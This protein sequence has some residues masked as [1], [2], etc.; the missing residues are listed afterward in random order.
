[1]LPDQ[2]TPASFAAYPPQARELAIRHIAILRRLP[3]AFLPLLL[4]E[5]IVYDWKFPAERVDLDRQFAYLG[6][7]GSRCAFQTAVAPF[8]QL[9]LTRELE[10]ADW[11]NSPA[12][13]SEQFS[14]HL[15]ATHQI[16]AFRAAAVD[17]VREVHAACPRSAA[18]DAPVR[19]R[20]NRA[21]RTQER[22]PPVP[23]ASA[24]GRLLY[25][26]QT[27][28]RHAGAGSMRCEVA[29]KRTRRPTDIGISTEA[30]RS[31]LQVALRGSPTTVSPRRARR[32]RA[33]CRKH[34]RPPFSIPKRFEPCWRR[35][36]PKRPA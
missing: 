9:R 15:W 10:N 2:L 29:P 20:G 31:A 19:H 25:A 36:S 27:R 1:M 23:Q 11:V 22:L 28:G 3:L 30:R 7:L 4:R 8:A 17:Y 16:D 21:G 24:Q 34:M 35:S 6:A 18:A 32:C 5:L 26:S 14:A 13:F 33:A 12:V